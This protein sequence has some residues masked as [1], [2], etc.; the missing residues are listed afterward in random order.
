MA[1]NTKRLAS[2]DADGSGA[3]IPTTPEECLQAN[4]ALLQVILRQ[5]AAILTAAET[6]MN[7]AHEILLFQMFPDLSKDEGRNEKRKVFHRQYD[8]RKAATEKLLQLEARMRYL[9][10]SLEKFTR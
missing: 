6:V 2:G 3:I 4:N 1:K 5:Q 10:L 9:E 8:T 7:T